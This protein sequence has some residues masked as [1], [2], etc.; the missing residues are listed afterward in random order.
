[1]LTSRNAFGRQTLP[2]LESS[3]SSHLTPLALY[4]DPRGQRFGAGLSAALFMI[5]IVS[6]QFWLAALLGLHLLVAS[7]FGSR[8]S[9][10]DARGRLSG[11]PSASVR[12][13]RSTSTRLVSPRR[14]AA[15]SSPSAR[16]PSY[17]A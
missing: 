8:R 7:A 17:L 14:S 5:A 16:L 6:Q 3:V 9:C 13:S 2:Q 10:L 1:M 4:I 15:S 12:Q 11:R